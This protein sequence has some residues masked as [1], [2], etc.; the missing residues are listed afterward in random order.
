MKNRIDV[1]EKLKII[2]L[3][4]CWFAEETT[5]SY[6]TYAD[7][8]RHET[9]PYRYLCNEYA[10][11]ED[12][13]KYDFFNPDTNKGYLIRGGCWYSPSGNHAYDSLEDCSKYHDDCKCICTDDYG[14]AFKLV[15]EMPNRKS[16]V[17]KERKRDGKGHFV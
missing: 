7:L 1:D 5:K 14:K 4:G 17:A 13:K 15:D 12:P 10:V 2:G 16:K 9:G 6:D 3:G 11:I 8:K